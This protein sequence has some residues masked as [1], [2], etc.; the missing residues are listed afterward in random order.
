M[1]CLA[2]IVEFIS[3][4]HGDQ[5]NSCVITELLANPLID[6][7]LLIFTYAVFKMGL[8]LTATSIAQNHYTV[9]I[10]RTRY[11]IIIKLLEN[12]GLVLDG[13]KL[14]VVVKNLGFS[15]ETHYILIMIFPYI[16]FSLF[17][18]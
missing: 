17:F 7:A 15:N 2:K 6:L 9:C 4:W 11:F 18:T 3:K 10:I 8:G 13:D 16:S 14:R 1:R 5:A 12:V